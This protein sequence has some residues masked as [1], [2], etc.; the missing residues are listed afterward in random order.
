MSACQCTG[1][2]G[3]AALAVNLCFNNKARES[4]SVIKVSGHMHNK[5]LLCTYAVFRFT[6][7]I[8]V[9]TKLLVLLL[10]S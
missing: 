3:D 4:A 1:D 8:L 7:Q 6:V 9:C 5:G 2:K 10:K